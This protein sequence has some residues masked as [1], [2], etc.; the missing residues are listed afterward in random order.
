MYFFFRYDNDDLHCFELNTTG[1]IRGGHIYG[2]RSV[3]ERRVWMQ[4]IAESLTGRFTTKLT[5][6]F[7]RMGWAYVREGITILLIQCFI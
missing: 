3:S 6:N 5:A 4:L 2:S 7:L 1:K